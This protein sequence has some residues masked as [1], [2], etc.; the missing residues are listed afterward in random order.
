MSTKFE[1]KV[2]TLY[3]NA[4]GRLKTVHASGTTSAYATA[5]LKAVVTTM[6]GTKQEASSKVIHSLPGS[7]PSGYTTHASTAVKD[8]I[9]NLQAISSVTGEILLRE[10]VRIKDMSISYLLSGSTT[11]Q[12]D[13]ANADIA[14]IGTTYYNSNGVNGFSVVDGYY[15][16]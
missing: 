15:V 10:A 9:L 14:L 1:Y 5:L 13:I 6:S 12:I 11:G 4:D 7:P 16:D 2:S 8:A 3:V